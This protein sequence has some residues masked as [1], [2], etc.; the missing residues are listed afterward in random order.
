MTRA[1][2]MK[3]S[4]MRRMVQGTIDAMNKRSRARGNGMLRIHELVRSPLHTV[5]PMS[6]FEWREL[7]ERECASAKRARKLLKLKAQEER[8]VSRG[9]KSRAG[10]KRRVAEVP[11]DFGTLQWPRMPARLSTLS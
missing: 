3:R 6:T 11:H 1:A 4:L 5:Q 8:K 10:R 7:L 2:F 9:K